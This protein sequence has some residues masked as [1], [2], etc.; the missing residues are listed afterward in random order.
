M[1]A[2]FAIFAGFYYW[3]GKISGYCYNEVLGKAHFW[4]MFI[5][6]N[7]TFF[8]QHFLGLAGLPR[9]YSDYHDSF[10]GWN[11]ISSL[12]SMVSIV[13]VVLFLYIIYEAYAREVKFQGWF[14]GDSEK[15]SSLEWIQASPPAHHTYNE[16]PYVVKVSMKV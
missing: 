3:F 15:S 6:V 13:G 14:E 11:Q 16:L 10:A 7:L 8:P 9:R 1:G 5:G 2:I 12:G 4:L